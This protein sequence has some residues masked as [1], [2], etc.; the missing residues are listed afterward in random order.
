MFD[1]L[2]SKL[3]TVLS[4]LRSRGR[5]KAADLDE[6]V[7]EIRTAL[8]ESDVALEVADSFSNAV[9]EQSLFVLEQINKSTNPSQGIFEIV[10]E[11]LQ[12]Y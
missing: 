4:S 6:I 5:I 2:T 11:N 8:I 10:I 1:S 3:G 9:K 12:Q 7:T